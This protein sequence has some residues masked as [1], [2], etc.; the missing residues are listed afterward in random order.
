[1]RRG[2]LGKHYRYRI[3]CT[4]GR[5]PLLGRRQ[6][7]LR[8]R[9]DPV[10]MQAAARA[11]AGTHDFGSFRASHCQA[12]TTERTIEAVT[13]RWGAEAFGPPHDLGR[14]DPHACDGGSPEAGP[15]WIDVDV[16]GQAFLYN[17][18]RIMVGTLV[19]VGLGRRAVGLIAELL[20]RPDRSKAG[21]TAP[22]CG[23][24]LIEVRWPGR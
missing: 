8:R 13:V 16:R 17:M 20:A 5:D 6:W 11:F 1:M 23:L 12:Q 14:L 18:V 22:A 24:T 21:P 4:R 19:D 7:H 2:N 15:D 10:A 9:L 3:R